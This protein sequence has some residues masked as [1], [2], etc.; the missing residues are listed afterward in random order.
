M[1][2]FKGLVIKPGGEPPQVEIFTTFEQVQR[3]VEGFVD[4]IELGID[5]FGSVDVLVNEDGKQTLPIN[6]EATKLLANRL[7]WGD[8]VCGTVV[9]AGE[10]NGEWR[11]VPHELVQAVQGKAHT[12]M[13]PGTLGG[14]GVG[15]VIT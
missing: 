13:F 10:K 14:D 3:T 2:Q 4:R 1:K 6:V 8:F 11:D 12:L 9:V 5:V 15:V 7:F